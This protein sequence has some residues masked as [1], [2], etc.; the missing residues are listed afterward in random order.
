[1]LPLAVSLPNAGVTIEGG[2]TSLGSLEDVKKE[3]R[4]EDSVVEN[5]GSGGGAKAGGASNE[6][7]EGG[8]DES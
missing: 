3:A 1:M 2:G 5:K 8:N 7:A 6:A 4:A